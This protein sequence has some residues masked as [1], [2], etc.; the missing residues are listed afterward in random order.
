MRSKRSDDDA[1]KHVHPMEVEDE[2]G[3]VDPEPKEAQAKRLGRTVKHDYVIRA[4]S[5]AIVAVVLGIALVSADT[6]INAVNGLRTFVTQYCS[7]WI[8]LC[9][10]LC[11]A[12]CVFV[13]VTKFGTIRLGGKDA[14]PAFSYFSWFAMLFATGQAWPRVLGRGRAHHDVRRDAVQQPRP[15]SRATRRSRGR[16]STGPS[17]RMGHLRHRVAVHVPRPLATCTRTPRSAARWRTCSPPREAPAARREI[18]VVIATIFGLTTSLGL[19][20]YQFNTG[21]QQIF[22][23]QTGKTLQVAF[24]ILFGAIATMSVW[25]GV[26]KGIKN[27]SR[28]ERDHLHRVRGGRVHLRPDAVHPRRAAPSRSACSSTSSC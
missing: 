18:L 12:V 3:E 17:P 13:A 21:I 1:R 2:S 6:F 26:V 22:N 14:K 23:I 5:V 11:F 10:F 27:I 7:W 24:V 15:C 9:A 4:V 8:V 19:A 25:F 20:S 16:T 28:R